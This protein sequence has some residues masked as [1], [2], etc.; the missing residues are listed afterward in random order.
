MARTTE[1]L[2]AMLI[3]VNARYKVHAGIALTG[4]PEKLW[5]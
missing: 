4:L 1:A 5:E 2:T 3:S